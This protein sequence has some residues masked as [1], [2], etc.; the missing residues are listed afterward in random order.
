MVS[1]ESTTDRHALPKISAPAQRAL[2]G[3]SITSLDDLATRAEAEIADL[4]GMGPQAL[5]I[6]RTAL[7]ER[8]MAFRDDRATLPKAIGGPA[9]G[10]L[11]H[12]GIS[13]LDDLA[14][15]TEREIAALHG[16]G[17]KALGI[18]REALATHGLAFKSG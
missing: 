5:G 6:L 9:T 13:S 12:A 1:N 17:P 11:I 8:G 7:A 18:L 3:A 14:G 2:T 15:H 16:M 10:A 4:H